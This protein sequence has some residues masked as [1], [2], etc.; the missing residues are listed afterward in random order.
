MPAIHTAF[1]LFLSSLKIFILW[2]MTISK[3]IDNAVPI[4]KTIS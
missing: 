1:S 3:V 4:D 2:L